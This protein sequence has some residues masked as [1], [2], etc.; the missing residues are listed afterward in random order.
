M[1]RGIIL[2]LMHD[3]RLPLVFNYLDYV[4]FLRD[5]YSI[6]HTFDRWFSYR[7]IQ[8]K[9]GIDPGYLYKVFQGKKALPQKK[10]P[11]IAEMLDFCK[12][13]KE[14]FSLLVLYGKAKSNEN[15]RRYFEK[16]LQF[17][18]IPT[19]TVLV[20]EYEYYT[21]RPPQDR[22]AVR[23]R[24]FW[25]RPFSSSIPPNGTMSPR[26]LTVPATAAANSILTDRM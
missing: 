11:A 5:Y 10:V 14:Y 26:Y 2:P 24:S 23:K 18:E 19:R 17:R 4:K 25:V 9:T 7:Y 20:G 13:E 6:R 12:R 8:G 3:S 1:A 16:L 22:G 21:K 15:I